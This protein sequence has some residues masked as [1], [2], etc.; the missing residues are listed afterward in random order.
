MT[1]LSPK[2]VRVLDF[3]IRY[4]MV[5]DGNSPSIRQIADGCNISSTNTVN[6]YLRR[7]AGA[8]RIDIGRKGESRH[9]QIPGAQWTPPARWKEA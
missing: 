5:H 9:I 2:M 4:K 1:L 8:G 7:L 3:I 6:Y